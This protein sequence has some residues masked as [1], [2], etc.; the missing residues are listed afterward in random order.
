[1]LAPHFGI[2]ELMYDV[3]ASSR[4]DPV[5]LSFVGFLRARAPVL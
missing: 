3:S 5:A 4:G 2:R 1:M